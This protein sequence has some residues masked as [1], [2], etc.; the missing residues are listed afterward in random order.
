MTR[1]K[2]SIEINVPPEIVWDWLL[3][4]TENY[5]EWHP[6]HITAFW[7]K[8]TPNQIGSI[9]Y[10]EEE[11]KGE[12]LKLSG[13]LIRLIPNKI[14]EYKVVGF[15]KIIVSSG[16]FEIQPIENGTLFTATLN[17]PLGKLLS[18]F[19]KKAVR[20]ITEHMIEEGENLKQILE[21]KEKGL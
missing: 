13:K 19:S 12:L 6:S 18:I 10:T 2:E 4:F 1:L 20:Q 14:F 21:A 11:I 5:C 16:T 8:G 3:H 17:F 15:L 7:K 9:M